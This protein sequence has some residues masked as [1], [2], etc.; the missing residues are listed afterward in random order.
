MLFLESKKNINLCE[1]HHDNNKQ[2]E[3]T[4]KSDGVILHLS[5]IFPTGGMSRVGANQTKSTKLPPGLLSNFAETEVLGVTS[6]AFQ[7]T[8]TGNAEPRLQ[9]VLI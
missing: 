8:F 2:R 3:R 1:R 6:A 4:R 5:L 9:P 7:G